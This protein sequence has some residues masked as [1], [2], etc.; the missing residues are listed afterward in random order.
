MIITRNP[1]ARR[2]LLRGL[3]TVMA[4]P[5]LESMV[6]T[7]RAADAQHAIK[8]LQIFYTPNGMIMQNYVPAETGAGYTITP[9]LKPLEPFRDRMVVVTGLAHANANA[10]GDG[11][12]DHGR[13]CGSYL[14][15]AHP[16]KTE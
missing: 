2:T 1:I 9:I 14:T 12:G 7:A 6:G 4:L 8:R 5:L 10:L 3:G 16:K 13:S 11:A 15:G